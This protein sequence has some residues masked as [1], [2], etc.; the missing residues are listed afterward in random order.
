MKRI[1]TLTLLAYLMVGCDEKAKLLPLSANELENLSALKSQYENEKKLVEIYKKEK[2]RIESISSSYVENSL[3]LSQIKIIKSSSFSDGLTRACR[4]GVVKNKGDEIIEE[5]KVRFTFNSEENKGVLKVWDDYLIDA[6]DDFIN[7]ER[8]DK[9]SKSL[10]LALSGITYPIKPN[11]S[12]KLPKDNACLNDSFIGW[13]PSTAT[14]EVVSVGIR[15]KMEE[16]DSI[17]LLRI[18]VKIGE[19]EQRAKENNQL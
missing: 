10:I 18:G 2:E 1:I 16:H 19:L 11:S 15:P 4:I 6:N 14:M 17:N 12:Y 13:N 8:V 9:Q 7:N 5:I 3:D